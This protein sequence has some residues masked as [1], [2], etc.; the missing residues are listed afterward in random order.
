MISQLGKL[1]Y[2]TELVGMKSFQVAKYAWNYF[3]NKQLPDQDLIIENPVMGKVFCRAET[4]DL[5]YAFY[6]YEKKVKDLIK[7]HASEADIF[8]DV[9]ACIGEFSVW[10]AQLGLDCFAFEPST[11]NFC[12]LEKNIELNDFTSKIKPFNFALGA[13]DAETDIRI[14]PTNKGYSGKYVAH[15]QGHFETI[16][17]KPLDN[18]VEQLEIPTDCKCIIKIDAEGMEPDVIDGARQFLNATNGGVIIFEAHNAHSSPTA[19]LIKSITEADAFI[20]DELNMA[21][22]Y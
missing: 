12:I 19:E 13:E 17:I 4:T 3:L 21:V 1:N 6:S 2:L 22:C 8:I 9:G 16:Q 15:K 20:V 5:M 10:A 11:E 7:K 18:L 14:H